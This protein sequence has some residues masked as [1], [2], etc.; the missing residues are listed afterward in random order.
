MLGTNELSRLGILILTLGSLILSSNHSHASTP[1]LNSILPRGVQRGQEHTL[2]FIG[3][4][5]KDTEEVFFYDDGI[6]VL[7]IEVKDDK[8]VFVQIKV[9]EGCRV[10][11]HVAQL[12]TKNGISDYRS[13]FIG[14]LPE[15]A[16]KE[17]NNSI[18]E[19]QAVTLNTTVTGIIGTEDIDYFQIAGKQGDRLSVEVEALRLGYLFDPAIALLDENRFEVAVSDD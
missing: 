19:S 11:E 12:R 15:L 9:D 8:Q 16:E 4:R 14:R 13:F 10:G 2:R 3:Q 18:D 17:P 7:N 1:R 5:L 6:S